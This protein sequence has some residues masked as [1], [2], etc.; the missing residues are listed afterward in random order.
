MTGDGSLKMNIL[1]NAQVLTILG[2][3]IEVKVIDDYETGWVG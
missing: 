2:R 1:Y 3:Y